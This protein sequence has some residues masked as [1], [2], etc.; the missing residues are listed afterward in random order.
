MHSIRLIMR[1]IEVMIG[2]NPVVAFLGIAAIVVL[3]F[4]MM[5]GRMAFLL[6]KYKELPETK[7]YVVGFLVF[8]G[9]LSVIVLFGVLWMTGSAAGY[10]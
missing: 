4:L 8:L 7:Q 1:G 9:I 2:E 10:R 3:A 6:R 5:N